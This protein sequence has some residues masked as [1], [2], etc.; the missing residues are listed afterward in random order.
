M[1]ITRN[2]IETNLT[3]GA[4]A[5]QRAIRHARIV[6]GLDD[7]RFTTVRNNDIK[8]GSEEDPKQENTKD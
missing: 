5:W 4:N 3:H 2:T 7:P 1:E 6:A 8:L